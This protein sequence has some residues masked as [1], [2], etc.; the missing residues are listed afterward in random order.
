MKKDMIEWKSKAVID[1]Q[2]LAQYVLGEIYPLH[3]QILDYYSAELHFQYSDYN[4]KTKEE[5]RVL[6]NILFVKL[7]KKFPVT[8]DRYEHEPWHLTTLGPSV[9]HLFGSVGTKIAVHFSL[10]CKSIHTLGTDRHKKYLERGLR[11]ADIGCFALT[12]ISHGSNVQGML[13]TAVFDESE[14]SFVI[15]TPTERA[16]KFWIGGASQTANMA[17][18]G[19]NLIVK[20]KNYGIH[21]FLVQIRNTQTHDLMPGVT[22]SDCGDKMGLNGI[23]NG[24]IFFRNVSVP[25]DSLLDKITQVSSQ[26]EVT[27]VFERSSQ[28]FAVQLSGLCDGRVKL[29]TNTALVIF[30]ASAIVLRYA[31]V[32]KQFG[33]SAASESN[34]LSYEQ[35]QSRVFPIVAWSTI[36]FFAIRETNK[37]WIKNW[38]NVLDPKN[39]EIKEMI[40]IISIMKPLISWWSN[41]A[42]NEHRQALG[43]YG[44]LSVS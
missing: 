44:Y 26:G 35:Y 9:G 42:L 37:L 34:L 32:R 12:E 13:T 33:E 28:R 1:P 19:A 7:M 17:I 11:L 38:M 40:A 43:G 6:T 4:S 41:D 3:K 27:S 20:E 31:T 21:M 30:R 10:Y 23:D 29:L 2:N 8:M 39:K 24:M 22:V 15:N 14:K 16:A 25:L 18:V 36:C 5:Q